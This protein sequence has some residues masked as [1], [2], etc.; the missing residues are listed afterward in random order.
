MY[1]GQGNCLTMHFSQCMPIVKWAMVVFFKINCIV[2][3]WG[4]QHDVMGYM[5]IVK[6]L[7]QWSKLANLATHTITIFCH[8]IY[9][10]NLFNKNPQYN[11]M[12][13]PRVLMLY[14]T[15]LDLF[16][17]HICT[18]YPLN[19]ISPFHL[20]SPPPHPQVHGNHCSILY[21]CIFDL[22][23]KSQ[24]RSVPHIMHV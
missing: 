8:K 16:I 11:T 21:L 23:F 10:F 19:H 22:L 3:I 18:F 13:F 6:W 9:L 14:I 12:L 24:H 15:S 17:L 20:P 2:Y 4:L 5:E 7:R 1:T